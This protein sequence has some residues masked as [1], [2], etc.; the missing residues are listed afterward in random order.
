MFCA[1]FHKVQ[2]FVRDYYS[3][4]TLTILS[5]TVSVVTRHP[6][7][8]DI[9]HWMVANRLQMNPAK[10]E[11]LCSGPAPNISMLGSRGHALALQ[12][13]SD[14]VTACSDH[15]GLYGCSELRSRADVIPA[16]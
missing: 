9:G 14:T 12:P 2:S 8:H 6:L 3:D 16:R 11:L 4:R 13:G 10:T 7:L 5:V 1:Q 15:V